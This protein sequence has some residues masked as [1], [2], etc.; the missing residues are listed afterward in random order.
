MIE[1]IS[2]VIPYHGRLSLFKETLESLRKQSFK[3]FEVVIS[4]DTNDT[5]NIKML[6]DSYSDLHIKYVKSSINL[7][8]IS[9]TLQGI[10]NASNNFIHILH[11]DDILSPNCIQFE[12]ELINKY[13]GNLFINHIHHAFENEFYSNFYN[14]PEVLFIYRN[15]YE[16][17]TTVQNIKMEIGINNVL[18]HLI[19]SH[20][21]EYERAE[22]KKKLKK[23]I[24]I[25]FSPLKYF[26]EPFAIIKY[27]FKLLMTKG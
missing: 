27:L 15:N 4:D 9:N 7:G 11:T 24:K 17:T 6:I 14:I 16:N 13:P 12:Q 26:L 18:N 23:H 5:E 19:T 22:I 21:R 10:N 25:M 8:A 2:I 1:K 3:D 20:P